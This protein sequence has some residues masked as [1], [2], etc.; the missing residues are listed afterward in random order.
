VIVRIIVVPVHQCAEG[1]GGQ[2]Q[3]VHRDRTGN[4]RFAGRGHEL[5][6]HHAHQGTG[7]DAIVLVDGGPALKGGCLQII[8]LHPIRDHYAQLSHTH[9]GERRNGIMIG[10]GMDFVQL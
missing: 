7:I 3:G 5:V 4:V 2:L 6:A 8:G 10:I 9:Q 1:I